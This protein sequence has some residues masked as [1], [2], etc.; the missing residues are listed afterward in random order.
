M[1]LGSI[2]RVLLEEAKYLCDLEL[3]KE[4]LLVSSSL[5]GIGVQNK[6]GKIR[7]VGKAGAWLGAFL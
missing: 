2:A 7:F 5:V 3:S 4:G 6:P 1:F